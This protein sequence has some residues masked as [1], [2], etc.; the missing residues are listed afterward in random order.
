MEAARNFNTNQTK[1][2]RK[3][4]IGDNYPWITAYKSSNYEPDLIINGIINKSISIHP[5]NVFIRQLKRVLNEKNSNEKRS[6]LNLIRVGLANLIISRN[7][8]KFECIIAIRSKIDEIL[9]DIFELSHSLLENN[10]T[11][12]VQTIIYLIANNNNTQAMSSD[13]SQSQY[14]NATIPNNVVI[15]DND[16]IDDDKDDEMEDEEF[17]DSEDDSYST[18]HPP[19]KKVFKLSSGERNIK[20]GKRRRHR[21]E[22]EE[23]NVI[24]RK[25]DA[26]LKSNEELKKG[27]DKLLAEISNIKN[28]N[29]NMNKEVKSIKTGLEALN[30]RVKALENKEKATKEN[31]QKA[32]NELS[33]GTTSSFGYS[34]IH[35][36]TKPVQ[37]CQTHD[38]NNAFDLAPFIEPQNTNK[39]YIAGQNNRNGKPRNRG[40]RRQYHKSKTG[41][42]EDTSVKAC[43]LKGYFFTDRWHIETTTTQVKQYVS[44]FLK[45]SNINVEEIKLKDN[46]RKAFKIVVAKEHIEEMYKTSNWP[47]F[48]VINKY[49]KKKDETDK[50][51]E[52]TPMRELQNQ[53]Y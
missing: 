20:N 51:N 44:S 28:N 34:N 16:D 13:G 21:E 7:Y 4:D 42:K 15:N 32:S 11:K 50:N 1:N 37:N 40:A 26:I 18:Q 30:E 43:E 22:E 35:S 49:F 46:T 24:F 41:E 23:E 33:R 36:R 29:S 10:I 14:S 27:H 8:S 31:A 39:W 38:T 19:C 5:K 53:D 17:D 2:K 3:R 25:L 12:N 9:N 6:L 47:K 48:I 52:R 45:D